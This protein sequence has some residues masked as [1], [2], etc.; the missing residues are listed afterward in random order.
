MGNGYEGQVRA[1][2]RPQRLLLLIAGRLVDARV[3]E[4]YINGQRRGASL[5]DV[6]WMEVGQTLRI[7]T[8]AERAKSAVVMGEQG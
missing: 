8:K 1:R 3:D 6:G 2:F 7:V 4:V 5:S